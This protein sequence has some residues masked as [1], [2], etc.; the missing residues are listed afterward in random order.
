VHA[1]AGLEDVRDDEA[2][3]E[4]ERR[5]DLEVDQRLRANAADLEPPIE[6]P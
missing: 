3:D 2:D 4:C 5:D 1:G 6:G